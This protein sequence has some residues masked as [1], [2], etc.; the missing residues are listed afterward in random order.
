M[1]SG[2]SISRIQQWESLFLR[3]LRDEKHLFWSSTCHHHQCCP[4]WRH[5]IWTISLCRRLHLSSANRSLLSMIVENSSKKRSIWN[6]M[7][8]L[9]FLQILLVHRYICNLYSGFEQYNERKQTV[10][11]V[12]PWVHWLAFMHDLYIRHYMLRRSFLPSFILGFSWPASSTN[13]DVQISDEEPDQDFTLL[14]GT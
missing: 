6:I 1:P 11:L 4:V 5:N 7:M 9:L 2:G 3:T 14:C 10:S 8:Y 12:Y 13:L